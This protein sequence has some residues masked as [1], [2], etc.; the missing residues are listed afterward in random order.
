MQGHC[1]RDTV[2]VLG[3]ADGLAQVFDHH[4]QDTVA[5]QRAGDIR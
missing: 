5:D 4:A 1:G 2:R 3:L